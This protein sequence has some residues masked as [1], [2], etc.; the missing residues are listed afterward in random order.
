MLGDAYQRSGKAVTNFEFSLPAA[1]SRRA[2]E[3]FKD[4]YL[5]DFLGATDLSRER[6][7]EQALVDHIQRFMLELGSGFAF[8]GRRCDCRWRSRTTSWIFCSIT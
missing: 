5:L 3:V 6:Q 7:I 1:E 2:T 8:V 4:P